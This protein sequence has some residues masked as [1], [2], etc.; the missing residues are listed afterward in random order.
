[1]SQFFSLLLFDMFAKLFDTT[2]GQVLVRLISSGDDDVPSCVFSFQGD[3]SEELGTVIDVALGFND[4]DAAQVCFNAQ[5]EYTC[6]RV[7]ESIRADLVPD[8]PDQPLIPILDGA[9]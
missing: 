1:V 4:W 6:A 7:A 5:D 8:A 2:A 3:Q 9:E